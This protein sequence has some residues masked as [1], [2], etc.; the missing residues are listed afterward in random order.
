LDAE[1]FAALMAPLAPFDAAPRLAV[2]VSGGPDSL[3]LALLADDWAR[4]RGGHVVALTVNHGLRPEAADEARQVSA[5]MA[6]AGV[7]HDTLMLPGPAPSSGVQ[8]WARARRLEALEAACRRLGLLDLLLAHHRDDQ[9]ETV[10]QRLGQGS[11]PDGLAAMAPVAFRPGVRLLRPLLPVQAGTL[12]AT[13]RTRGQDWIDDPS[14][15]DPAHQ[16]VRLR[17]LGPALAEAGVTPYGV[18]MAA[19]RA[20]EQRAERAE[21]IAARL[22]AA[23]RLHPAGVATV[24]AA[25]LLARPDSEARAALGRLLA[26]VGGSAR[27][28]REAALDRLLA[29]LRAG[30]RTGLTLGRCRWRPVKRAD[31]QTGWL[32]WREARHLPAPVPLADLPTLPADGWL[33]DGRFRVMAAPGPGWTLE[34]LGAGGDEALGAERTDIPRAALGALPV[35]RGPDGEVCVPA[36]LGYAGGSHD[37]LAPQARFA[38]RRPLVEGTTRLV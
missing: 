19:G 37:G 26:C 17:R 22:L 5:W 25:P 11:G 1:R 31:S 33:W 38:P 36:G 32:V 7:A 29:R 30:T 8:A 28:P 34:P 18:A 20:A 35:L 9:A 10:L 24:A 21:R 14:N 16:R 23:V 15:T 3:A 4:V 13:L 27:P 12:R 2:G 6:A